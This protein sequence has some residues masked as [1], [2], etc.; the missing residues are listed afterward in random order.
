MS[1]SH[2]CSLKTKTSSQHS[3]LLN[4]LGIS[5]PLKNNDVYLLGKITLHK[6]LSL[7][8]L[9]LFDL[10]NYPV[11]CSGQVSLIFWERKLSVANAK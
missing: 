9:I 1:Q 6:M 11:K 5:E 3:G 2:F 10:S 8:C 4:L 7:I